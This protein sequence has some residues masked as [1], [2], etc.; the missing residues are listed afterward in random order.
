MP[1]EVERSA[2]DVQ[3]AK[4]RKIDLMVGPFAEAQERLE[5]FTSSIYLQKLYKDTVDELIQTQQ[6]YETAIGEQDDKKAESLADQIKFLENVVA[7][8]NNNMASFQSG[9][10]SYD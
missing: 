3:V 5:D 6:A 2:R 10:I 9:D 8:A 4:D 7:L 1:R